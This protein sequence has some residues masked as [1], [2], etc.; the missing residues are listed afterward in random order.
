MAVILLL[1]LLESFGL[2]CI[3]SSVQLLQA[4]KSRGRQP[5]DTTKSAKLWP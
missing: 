1:Q 2:G 4:V 3:H 5:Q